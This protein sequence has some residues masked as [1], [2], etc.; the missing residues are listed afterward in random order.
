MLKANL[1]K[2][3]KE[4]R[5]PH[6]HHRAP[7]AKPPSQTRRTKNRTPPY[8]Y[9]QI[10]FGSC[11]AVAAHVHMRLSPPPPP[12]CGG[13][14]VQRC[15]DHDAKPPKRMN[16]FKKCKKTKSSVWRRCFRHRRMI[17]KNW[18]NGGPQHNEMCAR[19][20]PHNKKKRPHRLPVM[21][22]AAARARSALQTM[23]EPNAA[24]G[25]G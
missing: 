24:A 18:K 3:K 1:Q 11:F 9:T 8:R 19:G 10:A 12:P 2:K 21:C 6:T 14:L 17:K 7:V 20:R 4:N 23:W 16:Y 22:F 13:K 15:V 5:T 25:T